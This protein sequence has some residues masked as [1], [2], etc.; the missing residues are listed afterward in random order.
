MIE[1][2]SM[3]AGPNKLLQPTRAAE[4]FGQPDGRASARAAERSR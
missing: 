1:A 4:P 2:Q 3:R